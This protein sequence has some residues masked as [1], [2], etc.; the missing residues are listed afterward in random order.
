MCANHSSLIHVKSVAEII[1]RASVSAEIQRALETAV[2][3]NVYVKDKLADALVGQRVRT[4]FQKSRVDAA[5]VLSIQSV[6]VIGFDPPHFVCE[7]EF[8]ADV[9]IWLD[10]L[11]EG[12]R[13][14]LGDEE[15]QF[16]HQIQAHQV[17]LTHSFV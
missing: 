4:R 16:Y 2:D 3:N 14:V 6:N 17:T 8:E 10:E 13:N 12:Y 5:K 15:F 1:S 11:D 9:S 7:V